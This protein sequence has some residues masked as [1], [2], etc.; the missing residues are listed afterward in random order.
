[1]IGTKQPA[2]RVRIETVRPWIQVE[3]EVDNGE[4]VGIK[5]HRTVVVGEVI[6]V[7]RTLAAELCAA[8]KATPTDAPIGKPKAAGKGVPKS[9][10]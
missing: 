2:K 1:M 3:Q 6:E 10:S 8:G 4:V 9:E 7:E 5:T